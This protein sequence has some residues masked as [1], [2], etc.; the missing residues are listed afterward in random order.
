L[1]DTNY[2][3]ITSIGLNEGKAEIISS[4]ARIETNVPIFSS[5]IQCCAG[6]LRAKKQEKEIKGIFLFMSLFADDMILYSKDLK[7]STKNSYI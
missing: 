3:S 7:D 1:K 5:L 6:I 2:K 4:K